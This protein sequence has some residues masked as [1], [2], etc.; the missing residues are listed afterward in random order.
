M[1]ITIDVPEQH[2]LGESADTVASRFKLYT[3]L[4]LLD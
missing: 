4:M 3:A 2:L 1:Q